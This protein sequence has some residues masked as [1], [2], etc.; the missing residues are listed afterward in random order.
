MGR[1]RSLF[2]PVVLVL[3]STGCVTW[4]ASELAPTELI[5]QEAPVRVRVTG[6]DGMQL[7]LE[8]PQIRAGA[9][10]A[11]ASPGAMLLDDVRTIEVERVSVAR[12]IA[13]TAPAAILVAIVAIASCRCV[14]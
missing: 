13:L 10:V 2:V 4:R 14:S 12:T 3:M 9:I 5:Q 8:R 1:H 7:T 11:T 6:T